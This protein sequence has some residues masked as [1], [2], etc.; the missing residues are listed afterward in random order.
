[1]Y[2]R[3]VV[4]RFGASKKFKGQGWFSEVFNSPKAIRICSNKILTKKLFQ[5]NSI[6]SPNFAFD[7]IWAPSVMK[8][9]EG[10]RGEAMKLVSNLIIKKEEKQGFYFERF[11]ECDKEFRVHVFN[12]F[13]IHIDRKCLR[14]GKEHH[15]IKNLERY[16]YLEKDT[17]LLNLNTKID[18]IRAVRCLGL[19]FGAV[20]VGFNSK[21]KE[22]YIYEVNSAPGLRTITREKYQ[23][24][25]KEYI[26]FLGIKET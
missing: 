21:S 24:A 22:H 19:V 23:K 4:L 15:W 20:D 17:D 10:S 12:D 25:I 26:S 9:I 14:K 18:C 11:V 7:P 1:M 2:N 5:A 6:S 8:K 16:V 3:K 13:I